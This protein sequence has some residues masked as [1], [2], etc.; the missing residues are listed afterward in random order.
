M[1]I[2]TA[3]F[4]SICCWN[5]SESYDPA[6]EVHAVDMV[7]LTR[8]SSKYANWI[9]LCG[10]AFMPSA[11]IK[12]YS[13]GRGGR[14]MQSQSQQC[15]SLCFSNITIKLTPRRK[16]LLLH[17]TSAYQIKTFHSFCWTRKFIG[18]FTKD[19][20]IS[21]FWAKSIQSNWFY[22]ISFIQNYVKILV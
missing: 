2:R 22:H 15:Y 14:C 4:S 3:H 8:R 5:L 9:A 12:N 20:H 1:I 21:L 6:V 11:H 16:V 17:V 19:C 13:G 18:V 7:L 10:M